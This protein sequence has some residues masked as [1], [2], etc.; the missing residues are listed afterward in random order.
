MGP[1]LLTLVLA[2]ASPPPH[3]QHT[4]ADSSDRPRRGFGYERLGT[5]ALRYDRVQG[6]S[7]GLGWREGL[8]ADPATDLY[9]TA[10][11]G[12]SDGRVTGRVTVARETGRSRLFVSAYR[13]VEGVAPYA[14]G[15]GL[16]NTLD[17]L[18]AG[19]DDADY[20]LLEGGLAG[21][22][23]PLG[24]LELALTA[25]LDRWRSVRRAAES[26][27]ND[28][29]GGSGLFPPN[30]PVDEGTFGGLAARVGGRGAVRWAVTAD[31]LVG[32]G[33]AT[34]RLR[35][36]LRRD[37]GR[38]SGATLRLRAGVATEPALRQMRFRLGGL[39]TV[40]GFDYGTRTGVAFWALQVDVAP[41]RG[42]IRPV[43]F[44]DAGQAAR[45]SALASSRILVGGGVGVALL[46]GLLRLDLSH[47]ISPPVRGGVRVDVVV[48]AVR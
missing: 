36:E 12:L 10:R 31:G 47:P 2:A 5:D 34:G 42:R 7:L 17:A 9:L 28:F 45:A 30:P 11:Y 18:F 6:L 35:G 19:R 29:L 1:H 37:V 27:V 39:G 14:A 44:L 8:A 25:R 26:E 46:G 22:V 38:R 24:G 21:L 48:Q 4:P 20:A 40:R 16:G 15:P 43:I 41:L 23:G 32:E 33:R 13:D 3:V